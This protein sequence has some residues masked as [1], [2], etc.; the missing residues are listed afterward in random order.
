MKNIFFR[1]IKQNSKIIFF[2]KFNNNISYSIFIN[3]ITTSKKL[4]KIN[5]EEF[6]IFIMTNKT[7]IVNSQIQINSFTFIKNIFS[8]IFVNYIL[9]IKFSNNIM[10]KFF[11][12]EIISQFLLR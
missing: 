4:I 5:R 8:Y 2:Q 7:S 3:S 9:I 1:I 6:F 12:Q 10:F 11:V